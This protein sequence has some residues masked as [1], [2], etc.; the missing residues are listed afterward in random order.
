MKYKNVRRNA[1]K[2]L[3]PFVSGHLRIIAQLDA[4]S[5]LQASK[6]NVVSERFS[7]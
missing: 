5:P 6:N 3:T 1:E 4:S 2:H 7:S